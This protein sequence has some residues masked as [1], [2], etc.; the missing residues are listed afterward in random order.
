ML[1]IDSE[2]TLNL[3]KLVPLIIAGALLGAGIQHG[4]F[5]LYNSV[6]PHAHENGVIHAH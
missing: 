2:M 3:L 5:H 4:Q 6:V 1:S